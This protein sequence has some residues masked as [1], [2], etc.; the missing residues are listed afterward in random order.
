LCSVSPDP[1]LSPTAFH[2]SVHNAPSGYWSIATGCRAPSTS[3]CCHDASFAAGLLEAAV[4][5]TV[6][7]RA[8]A[9]IAYDV[10]YPEPLNSARPIG[11]NFGAGLVLSPRPTAASFARIRLE[12]GSGSGAASAMASAGL[13]ELRRGTPAARCLPIL[14]AL[15]RN[16]KETVILEYVPGLEI[17]VTLEPEAAAA[18]AAAGRP[19][20]LVGR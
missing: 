11:A 8:V 4:Q 19:A 20:Q 3:L 10:R 16:A 1:E 6:G 7:D 12:L 9:L 14:A 13:E 15:A 2:N 17:A 5:A 18:T